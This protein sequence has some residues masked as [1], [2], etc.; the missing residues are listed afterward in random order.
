[1]RILHLAMAASLVLSAVSLSACQTTNQVDTAIEQNLP[2]VCSALEIAHV[3]FS[4]VAATG[5]IKSTTVAKETAAYSGVETICTDP[6]HTTAVNA[7]VLVAQAYA[8]VS[9]A[10]QQAKAA[11]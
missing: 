4:A 6:S 2:K 7:L 10:L 1:M 11:Q 9:S 3:A 8:I 5:K